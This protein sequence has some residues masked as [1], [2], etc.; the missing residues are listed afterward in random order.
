MTHRATNGHLRAVQNDLWAV[1]APSQI[2]WPEIAEKDFFINV[3][4]WDTLEFYPGSI[5][6][7]ALNMELCTGTFPCA[8]SLVGGQ[9]SKVLQKDSGTFLCS[10]LAGCNGV[11]VKKLRTASYQQ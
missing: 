6:R 5:T 4:D 2:D 9:D 3:Y 11:K 10:V 8:I 1:Y 7:I